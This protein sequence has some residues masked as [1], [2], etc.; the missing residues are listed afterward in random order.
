MLCALPI[1]HDHV[2]Q[3]LVN[4]SIQVIHTKRTKEI[5]PLPLDYTK[6]GMNKAC[7]VSNFRM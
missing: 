4:G 3:I 2:N 5:E 1:D 6:I 7:I